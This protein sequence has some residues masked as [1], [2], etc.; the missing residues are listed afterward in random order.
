MDSN[1]KKL[2]VAFIVLIGLMDIYFLF[3]VTKENVQRKIISN[4]DISNSLKNIPFTN[5]NDMFN[6][7]K[8]NKTCSTLVVALMNDTKY[9]NIILEDVPKA[10]NTSEYYMA[11]KNTISELY[12]ITSSEEFENF[13]DE[14]KPLEI[15]NMYEVNIDTINNTSDKYDFEIKLKGNEDVV[16]PVIIN[17]KDS[18]NMKSSSFWN[19][20]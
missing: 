10:K 8:D 14:L 9:I 5:M 16:I 3:G 13:Y 12:G 20:R 15:L 11:N 18:K 19:K 6:S 2:I 4:N 7:I 17:V 1:K